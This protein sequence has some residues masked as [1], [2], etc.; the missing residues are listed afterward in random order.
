ME[1]TIELSEKDQASRE[2]ILHGNMWW[3]VAKIC[4]PLAIFRR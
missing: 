3:V 2:F 4:L 1:K